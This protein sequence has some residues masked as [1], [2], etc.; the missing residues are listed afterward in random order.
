MP[1]ATR[2]PNGSPVAVAISMPAMNRTMYA[3][4]T[5]IEPTRP[6]C[7]PMIAKI[8]SLRA[9]AMPW[10]DGDFPGG[11]PGSS[12]PNPRR[13]GPQLLVTGLAEGLGIV[14]QQAGHAGCWYFL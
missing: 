10:L 13:Q 5:A 4:S 12:R 14:A 7:S 9:S 2:R 6:N 1:T 11:L 3:A 8:M